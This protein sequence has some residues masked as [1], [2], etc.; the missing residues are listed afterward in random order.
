MLDEQLICLID[1]YRVKA[2]ELGQHIECKP[3]DCGMHLLMSPSVESVPGLTRKIM[4]A[5]MCY[6][7]S[8]NDAR[9]LYAEPDI[10]NTKACR[11]LEKCGFSFLQNIMLSTKA[12]SLY[13]ITRNQFYATRPIS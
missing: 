7:F 11:L 2:D 12:A 13:L 5:F 3:N 10:H 6:L 1:V 8:F 9:Y 4:D